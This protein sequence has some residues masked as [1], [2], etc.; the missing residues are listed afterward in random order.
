MFEG[1]GDKEVD[2]EED[3]EDGKSQVIT[4]GVGEDGKNFL[5]ILENLV[6]ASTSRTV[7]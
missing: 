4:W 2:D 7:I 3:Y 1:E 6:M 5:T